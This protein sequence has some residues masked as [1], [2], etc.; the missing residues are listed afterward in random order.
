[1]TSLLRLCARVKNIT[2]G[3]LEFT[4]NT[5]NCVSVILRAAGDTLFVVNCVL[6]K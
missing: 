4:R 1:M 3:T 2:H 6:S 5:V